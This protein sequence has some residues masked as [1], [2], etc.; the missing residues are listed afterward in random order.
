MPAT[1]QLK[2]Y[3]GVDLSQSRILTSSDTVVWGMGD[4]LASPQPVAKP[5]VTGTCFS[6]VKVFRWVFSG[7]ASPAIN[8]LWVA[9]TTNEPTVGTRFWCVV[10]LSGNVQKGLT[11]YARLAPTAD[12]NVTPPTVPES[13]QAVAVPLYPQTLTVG[14]GSWTTGEPSFSATLLVG[15]DATAPVGSG[16]AM[17]PLI[18]GWTQS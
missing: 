5:S 15:V 12:N 9:K 7:T 3:Y 11:G 10:G 1:A 8:T 16:L 18:F 13:D 6:A 17:P 4:G 2:Y 14:T